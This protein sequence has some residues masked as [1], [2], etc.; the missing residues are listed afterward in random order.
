MPDLWRGKYQIGDCGMITE[1]LLMHSINLLKGNGVA[2]G[3]PSRLVV[4]NT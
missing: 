2:P 3:L 1:A 4:A